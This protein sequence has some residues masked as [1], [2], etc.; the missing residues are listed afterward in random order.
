MMNESKISWTKLTWNPV[1]GCSIVS[2]G[3]KFCYAATLSKR[4]G[5]TTKP[6]TIQNEA[7]NVL[8]KPHKLKEPYLIKEPSRVFVNS[9][10]DLFHR[11]IPDWYRAA[12]FSVM[13]DLPQHTF[14]VLT[15]R[16]DAT[17]DWHKRFNEATASQAY[18]DFMQT[19]KD[20]R[21]KAALERG[22]SHFISPW[23]K[24]IWMGTSVEDNRVLHRIDAL[25]QCKAQVRFISA[26]PLIGAWGNDVD[27]TDIH[28]VIVG[29]ESGDHMTEG[30]ER[31]MKQEWAREIRDLC[32]TQNVA[33]FYKQDSGIRTEMRT[34][35]VEEDGSKWKWEQYPGEL[36]PA[37]NMD[38]GATW[39]PRK[40]FSGYAKEFPDTDWGNSIPFPVTVPDDPQ[41]TP[42]QPLTPK[43]TRLV[44]FHD[45]VKHWSKA[46]QTWDSDEFMYIGRYNGA[47][48]L[49][50]S[51]WS[52]PYKIHEDTPE[53]RAFAI[54]QY[55]KHISGLLADGTLNLETLRGKTLVCW[56]SP[57]HCHGD[58]LLELLG[59][60]PAQAEPEPAAAEQQPKQLTLFDMG[61]P[62]HY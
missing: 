52:N 54:E 16:A 58:V 37:T 34:Y 50:S 62:V 48:L 22:R 24:N 39:T 9:M 23:G 2:D 21:V 8:M 4:Y 5:W 14:Q 3:C 45:V 60:T 55:R 41:P 53:T 61:T 1:S 43:P 32:V 7:E 31:W 15:K 25:R 46:N 33:Y 51:L 35:L 28:W 12:V 20:K 36:T 18:F 57:K 40:S 13:L 11:Q 47:Y 10:S 59:K 49:P 42:T 38:T 6:W 27:L 19:V 30:N 56:C 44:N 29:G 17:V 26:E